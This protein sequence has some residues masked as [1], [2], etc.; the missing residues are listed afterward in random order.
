MLRSA[1]GLGLVGLVFG[2]VACGSPED[3]KPT[4]D[5]GPMDVA[6]V[7]D[8][9]TDTTA[10]V[11]ENAVRKSDYIGFVGDTDPWVLM[12]PTP[13]KIL[14]L[15][16]TNDTT[17]SPIRL[18]VA[19]FGPDGKAL[20][21]KGFSGQGVQVVDIQLVAKTAGEYRAVVRDT[22]ND[23]LDRRNAY[24]IQA[25][26]LDETDSNEPNGLVTES[27]PVTLGA[28]VRGT[29]GVQGD[30]DWFQVDVPRDRLIRIA[31]APDP[32]DDSPTRLRWQLWGPDVVSDPDNAQ[33]IA[34][35]LEPEGVWAPENRAVGNKEGRYYIR[36]EDDPADG[37]HAD[38]GRNY[39]LTVTL[40]NEP[41]SN[42][43]PDPNE[44]PGSATV[45]SSGAQ[46][47]GY[48]AGVSDVDYYAINVP[49]RNQLIQV[50]A[51]MGTSPVDLS[52]TLF[53]K[54]GT[55][56]ICE[57]RDGDL[58][59]AT[60]FRRDGSTRSQNL[61][62]SHVA[63]E[64]GTYFLVVRDF[65]D[66]EFD[67]G[68][69]YTLR[70]D[71]RNDP[72][73]RED[74]KTPKSDSE[75]REQ[76]QVIMAS[77]STSGKTI[78]FPAVTGYIGYANDQDW[79]RFHIPGPPDPTDT[80]H[81]DQNGDWLIRLEL[82]MPA[83]EVELQAFFFGTGRRYGG[84]GQRCRGLV[85]PED[86]EPCQYSPE[87]NAVDLDVGE[88]V[89]NYGGGRENCFVVFREMTGQGDH[90]F[91]LTDLDRDDFDTNSQYRL[92]VTLT[93]GCA[94]SGPEMSACTGVA[95]FCGRP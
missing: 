29:L 46:V 53:D 41:D 59:K 24:F 74:F 77:T 4:G 56:L 22:G 86:P 72:D 38:L 28:P 91:R 40:E 57:A 18:Q 33:V 60:R 64:S 54:D 68:T 45:L 15:M 79:Y 35:S 84:Y 47:T 31:V 89:G 90:F 73:G 11:L 58:C 85:S 80:V 49:R 27:T 30:E 52:F 3:T 8:N 83:S 14:Q 32:K 16:V 10:C 75:G 50:S 51:D 63:S 1:L 94:T 65:Q 76:A 12:V 19:L 20:V 23:G 13:G 17:I 92:K 93:A 88:S 37:L 26:L 21:T 43:T 42:E 66:N 87:D 48:I 55:T 6:G 71:V 62:T 44:D 82:Q 25:T 95:N 5:A 67:A 39:A 78:E 34:D 9:C 81:A 36:I 61:R 7:A 69:P 2:F 70:V